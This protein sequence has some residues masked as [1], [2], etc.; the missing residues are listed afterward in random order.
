M[1][2]SPASTVRTY[3]TIWVW[4]ASLMFLGVLLSEL[5]ISKRTIVLTV[6]GLSSI[7]AVLVAMYY[8][9]LKVDQRLLTWVLLA[10]VGILLLVIGLLYS[11]HLVRL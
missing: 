3:V 10:P 8:M 4:L 2:D 7:K 11:S 5:H 9:H 6:L 1:R